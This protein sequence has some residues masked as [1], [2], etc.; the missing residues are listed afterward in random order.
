MI[1]FTPGNFV[2][3]AVGKILLSEPFMDDAY[4]GRKAVLLCEH[5]EEGS[6]GV[7]LNNFIEVDLH[8]LLS[9]IFEWK[10]RISLGG[11]VKNSNLY[12]LHTRHDIPDAIQV[13]QGLFMGGDFDWVKS[14]VQLGNIKENELRFFIGY[15]GWTPGQLADE[16]RSKSWFMADAPIDK[17]MDTTIEEEDYWKQL[18]HSM[19]SGFSHIANAPIDPSLN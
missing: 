10:A 7:V 9:G 3:P 18:I 6:F 19:G 4:F 15:A 12:Y 13:T 16:V 1:R 2:E 17:I 8:E 11:P 5:N 14:A